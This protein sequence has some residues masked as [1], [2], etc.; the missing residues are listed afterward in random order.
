MSFPHS[1]LE[2][3][4]SRGLLRSLH[5]RAA[6][7]GRFQ[8]HEGRLWL[9]FSSNDY[10]DLANDPRLKA[11]ARDAIDRWGC[12][13]TA[14]RLMAGHLDIHEDLEDALADF[15]GTEGALVFGSGF[16]A[17]MG[18]LTTLAG[19]GG[20]VFADRLN[21]ASLVDGMRLSGARWHRYRHNDPADLE[22]LLALHRGQGRR[23]VVTDSVFSMDGDIAPLEE[24]ATLA[25]R[26]EALLIVDEAHA[27]GIQGEGGR[28]CC[29][30]L[31]PGLRPDFIVGTLSKSLGSYGGF[32]ACTRPFRDLLVNRA[33][34]FIYSTGLPPAAAAA[35]R[36][37]L[38]IIAADPT[39]A[40][41]LRE[42]SAGFSAALATAG[43][44]IQSRDSQIIA[45][46]VGDNGETAGRAE[47]LQREG[48]LVTA[49][50]PPTVPA[51]T[52]R[53]RL[54][55]TLAHEGGDLERA[56]Q[57]IARSIRGVGV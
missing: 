37:A 10:L 6:T 3:L 16:L 21:H 25:R 47:A 8:D 18:L 53:L 14:S 1:D 35:A 11:A 5:P 54:S 45:I 39:L 38:R 41:R 44:E 15:L 17:N 42:R 13:A 2:Q 34:S 22:R 55:V 57:L 33:R 7:G 30:G 48:L 4:A 56:A 19:P 32:V 31:A 40:T 50:R 46:I 9:N 23:V 24:I 36:E 43:L 51:G 12:G 28:G 29:R 49:I 27:I 52:A 20:H 26:E